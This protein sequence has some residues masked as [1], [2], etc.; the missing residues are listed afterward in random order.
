MLGIPVKRLL[1]IAH[2]LP[3]PPDKGERVRAFEQ[4][5]ALSARFDVTLAALVHRAGAFE[6]ARPLERYCRKLLLARAGGGLG[7]L[8]G[9]FRLLCGGCVTEGY[10]HSRA[11]RRLLAAEHRSSPFDLVFAYCSSTIPLA[12]AVDAPAR[13]IDLVD[14]DSAKWAAYA[15]E[16]RWPKSWVFRR[17]AQGVG[18]LEQR[19]IETFDRVLLV[20]EA[21]ADALGRAGGQQRRAL[22]VPNGVDSD[23]F[24][25]EA[26]RADD[27]GPPSLVFTGTMDY[28][29]N[30][31]GVCWFVREVWPDLKRDVPELRFVIVGRDPAKAVEQLARQPGIVVTGTVDDVRPY[32]AA[33]RAV[34]VPLR[35]ARGIQNK[36]LQAMAMGKA[37]IASPAALEGLDVDVGTDALEADTPGEW[38]R[39]ITKLLG[40][41]ASRSS[42]GRAARDRVVATYNWSARLRPLVELCERLAGSPSEPREAK[43]AAVGEGAG[44]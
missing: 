29:P 23:Y 26:V 12:H 18:R 2:R 11:M 27:G 44:A 15:D 3:Y 32:L 20:S 8:R 40:D 16:A 31:D 34:V 25:A 10:F 7:L 30:V 42:L 38:R 36:L 13:V 21:E 17:E 41:G 35:I 37:V 14:V 6:L 22:G 39:C 5:K 24:R 4:I 33:A 1:Y 43:Q 9:G 28:R 19:A